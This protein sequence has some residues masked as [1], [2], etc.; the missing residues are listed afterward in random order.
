MAKK[1]LMD[2]LTLVPKS[3]PLRKSKID[4]EE[5]EKAVQQIHKPEPQA[6]PKPQTERK[7]EK[8]TV[9]AAK[10]VVEKAAKP[11][12]KSTTRPEGTKR[13]TLDIPIYLHGEIK[14]KTFREGTT[15]KEYLL[16]LVERD[17][18]L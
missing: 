18:G 2:A 7:A 12:A 9:Q 16:R 3:K 17:L 10:P 6:K 14:M 15:I 5:T 4:V 8:R 13:V 1:S 11:S